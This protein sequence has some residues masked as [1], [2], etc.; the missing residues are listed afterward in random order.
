MGKVGSTSPAREAIHVAYMS[1]LGALGWCALLLAT[2]VPQLAPAQPAF[3]GFAPF[4]MFLLVV[5]L[6]RSMAYR[7]F[8]QAPVSLDSALYVASAVCLGSV[9]AAWM[10]GLGLLLDA[11]LR[12]AHP[13]FARLFSLSGRTPADEPLSPLGEVAFPFY[14][15]G[16][17][18]ALLMGTAWLFGVDSRALV[19]AADGSALSALWLVP[20]YGLAF[21]CAHYAIQGVRLWLEGFS[22]REVLRGMVLPGIAA[23]ATLLPLAVVTVF[24]YRPDAPQT[25]VLLGLTYLLI[26]YGFN[27]LSRTSRQLQRRVEELETL[28]R[29]GRALA[30]SLELPEIV[31]RVCRETAE[32]VPSARTVAIGLFDDDGVTLRLDA[33]DRDRQVF[34]RDA[35]PQGGTLDEQVLRDGH[36]TRIADVRASPGGA[37]LADQGIRARVAVPLRRHDTIAGFVEVRSPEAGAFGADEVR[38]LQAI[39]AQAS[40][41][42]QNA[43]LYELATVDGLTGLYTRRYFDT[44]LTEELARSRRFGTAFSLVILDLDDFKRV[45]DTFGHPAGD[46]VL[47]EAARA[48]RGA[49]RGIDIAARWGGEE[50]AFILPRTKL[51]EAHAVA[52]RVRGDIV[53]TGTAIEGALVRVTASMGVACFPESGAEDGASLVRAADLALY[54]AKATGKD[55]V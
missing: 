39:A 52:E 42:I 23:E 50:F 25:L 40:M 4:V 1:T 18:A 54:H 55:R 7:I 3:A 33:Y 31:E 5:L 41:A 6:A 30:S 19:G 44:R 12:M 8:P 20:T 10:V 13:R 28:H 17:S 15:G 29:T 49:L 36:T 9:T 26:N 45:N 48:M 32:A 46:R 38:L 14:F 51:L 35:R 47:R 11:V 43:R 21:L 53:A 37:A 34:A 16:V 2:F 22:P 24:V 27:R